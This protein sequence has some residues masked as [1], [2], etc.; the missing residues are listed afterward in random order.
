VIGEFNVDKNHGDR[1][2]WWKAIYDVVEASDVSGDCFWWYMN[3]SEDPEY[4]IMVGDPELN[5]FAIHAAVMLS[6]STQ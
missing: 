1:S 6:K 4:G 3:K 5:V 2:V